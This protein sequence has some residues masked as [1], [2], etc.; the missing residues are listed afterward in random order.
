MCS[1]EEA[2]RGGD[3]GRLDPAK[4]GTAE[5]GGRGTGRNLSHL[6]QNKVCGW[7][8]THLQ[9]LQHPLLCQMRGQSYAAKQ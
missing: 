4:V 2:G 5:E 8:R 1:Q 3:P 7:H 9:L 6:P